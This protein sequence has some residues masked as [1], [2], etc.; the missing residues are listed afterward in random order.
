MIGITLNYESVNW[1][2]LSKQKVALTETIEVLREIG[3]EDRAESLEGLVRFVGHMEELA[4]QTR[5]ALMQGSPTRLGARRTIK[6]ASFLT[7]HGEPVQFTI[8]EQ[9]PTSEE[10]AEEYNPAEEAPFVPTVAENPTF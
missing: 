8:P 2:T 1:E 3:D 6:A 9:T 4:Q 7:S 10:E 5:N